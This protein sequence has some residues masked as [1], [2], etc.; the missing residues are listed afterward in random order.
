LLT[1]ATKNKE[2]NAPY[3]QLMATS[4]CTVQVRPSS[5]DPS[6]IVTFTLQPLGA[7]TGNQS[8]DATARA[9]VVVF[10][11]VASLSARSTVITVI[12]LSVAV[13]RLCSDVMARH[14]QPCFSLQSSFVQHDDLRRDERR[15]CFATPS[16]VGVPVIIRAI[17]VMI[18][19]R[20]EP[21]G[22]EV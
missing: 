9:V 19:D 14:L 2:Q 11:Q 1:T 6:F 4:I 13:Y 5:F 15:R 8:R 3:Q 22:G 17:V 21:R 10:S 18:A 20:S 7:G 16:L 12:S